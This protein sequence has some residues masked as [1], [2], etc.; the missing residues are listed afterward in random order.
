[1]VRYTPDQMAAL[2]RKA[3]EMAEEALSRH[4]ISDPE[5]LRHAKLVRYFYENLDEWAL[6][7]GFR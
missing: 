4:G 6:C 1:M 5:G 2:H 3:E 7:L